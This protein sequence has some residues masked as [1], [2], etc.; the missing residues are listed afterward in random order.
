MSCKSP[1]FKEFN[2][3]LHLAKKI[4]FLS[5]SSVVSCQYCFNN[6][7]LCVVMSDYKKCVLCT[8][9]EHSCVSVLWDSLD[10]THNKLKFNILKI[11]S[12]QS[13][14]F[15]EQSEAAACATAEWSHI[16]AEQSHVTAKLD[17]LCKTLCQT[18]DHAKKKTLCLLQELSD[19]EKTVKN[20]SAETLSQ[21]FNAM[22]VKYWQQ[23]NS[24]FLPQNVE[25]FSHSFWGFVWVPK[26]TLRYCIFFTWQDSE[27]F[28]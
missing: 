5:Y 14:L 28:H 13:C 4:S 12:E 19:D 26:L 27:L 8:H 7:Q 2:N 9:C 24:S 16:T 25:A 10:K 11:E 22:P 1:F 21:I 3:H 17:H 18:H 20:P 23:S 6:Q 15:I